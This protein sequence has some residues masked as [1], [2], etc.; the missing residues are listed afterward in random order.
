MDR[1]R[2]GN[3]NLLAPKPATH[4]AYSVRLIKSLNSNMHL[5]YTHSP[6]L[7]SLHGVCICHRRRCVQ[8]CQ[9]LNALFI[10]TNVHSDLPVHVHTAD[11]LSVPQH[12]R[13]LRCAEGPRSSCLQSAYGLCTQ[14]I[15]LNRNFARMGFS[16]CGS[17]S[18][19]PCASDSIG[20]ASVYT[21]S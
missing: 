18:N 6:L 8:Q 7:L 2:R 1:L 17:D 19:G 5:A 20:S 12:L 4:A 3:D 16:E 13:M 10:V 9:A 21:K 15:A 11:T 14:T